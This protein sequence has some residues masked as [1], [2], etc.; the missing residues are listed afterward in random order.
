MARL[1]K[2]CIFAF[3]KSN[4]MAGISD[5]IKSEVYQRFM[6]RLLWWSLSV[7]VLGILFLA[8]KMPG[9]NIMTIVGGGCLTIRMVFFLFEK[10]V[11]RE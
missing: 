9:G 6:K 1:R 5:F 4:I 11:T 3:S 7:F 8:L 10:L 2:M